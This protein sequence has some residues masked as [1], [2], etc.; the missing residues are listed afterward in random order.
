[1]HVE[2]IGFFGFAGSQETDP[3]YI[4]TFDSAKL[5]AEHGYDVVNGGGPGVMRAA[6]LGAHAGG[7]KAIGVTYYPKDMPQFE[8]RDKLNTFDEEIVTDNYVQRT[9]GIM[10]TADM[11]VVMN[12]GT[13]T[14]SEFGMAWGLARIHFG[15]HKPLI[16]F[17]SYWHDIME[18]IAKGMRIRDEAVNIGSASERD[19]IYHIV[20]SPEEVL[21]VVE[22]FKNSN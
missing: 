16:L 13:G 12:G 22:S 20:D 6:T 18:A 4:A 8:G 2:K 1:M 5:L 14:V 17:G 3:E 11:Y 21:E 15:N 10:D 19:H 9:L 7:G